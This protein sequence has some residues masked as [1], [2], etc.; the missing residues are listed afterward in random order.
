MGRFP[1]FF[2]IHLVDQGDHR[3]EHLVQR[4]VFFLHNSRKLQLFFKLL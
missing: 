1:N 4:V 2:S 3:G